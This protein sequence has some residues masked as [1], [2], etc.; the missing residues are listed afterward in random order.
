L[1]NVF[2]LPSTSTELFSAATLEAMALGIPAI[3]TDVGSMKEMVVSNDT[4][5]LV[6][7]NDPNTLAEK[8]L[9]LLDNPLKAEQM[10]IA[11]KLR[12]EQFFT[13]QK[14][15]AEIQGLLLDLLKRKQKTIKN[16]IIEVG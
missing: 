12:V 13:A 7:P 10:G 9:Y 4:G 15:V 11:A 14:E 2:T 3:V 16:V 8:I 6:P 5:Y 1:F